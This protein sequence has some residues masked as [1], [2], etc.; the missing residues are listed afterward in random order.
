VTAHWNIGFLGL[1]ALAGYGVAYLK[2][3]GL[4]LALGLAA[5]VI[6]AIYSLVQ[7]GLEGWVWVILLAAFASGLAAG[8]FGL[9]YLAGFAVTRT[10]R[11][12]VIRK[13]L[14]ALAAALAAVPF[15]LA[16]RYDPPVERLIQDIEIFI[17]RNPAVLRQTGDVKELKR[18][19]QIS[20]AT[21]AL[22]FTRV[23]Y[24]A[25][26]SRGDFA[27]EVLVSGTLDNPRLKLG[28]VRR[29]K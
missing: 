8:A 21:S 20:V 16:Y 19:S 6:A 3:P 11:R 14:L 25:V 28:A 4:P 9:G 15:W 7:F 1:I 24:L 29:L 22:P 26:G 23:E 18:S 5:A 17:V 27:V 13:T 10:I 12:R 2:K